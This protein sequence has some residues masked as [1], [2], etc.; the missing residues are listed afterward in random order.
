[1]VVFQALFVL[2]QNFVYV[3]L[4][5]VEKWMDSFLKYLGL[6][7]LALLLCGRQCMLE[8]KYL[9]LGLFAVLLIHTGIILKAEILTLL[10][11]VIGSLL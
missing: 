1:M 5:R 7:F 6:V 9:L 8:H 11:S 3:F 2:K 4:Q 10:S